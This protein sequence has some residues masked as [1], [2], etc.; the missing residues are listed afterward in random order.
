MSI[1]GG[2]RFSDFGKSVRSG[3]VED[4]G[5]IEAEVAGASRSPS[6]GLNRFRRGGVAPE[7]GPLSR[8][9]ALLSRPIKD[10]SA[11]CVARSAKSQD[12][13]QRMVAPPHN[14]VAVADTRSGRSASGGLPWRS[15]FQRGARG[16]GKPACPLCCASPSSE[17]MDSGHS[18][19]HSSLE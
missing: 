2:R 15:R 10:A 1:L 13:L 18:Q 4:F 11:C 12:G 6:A 7:S 19:V 9:G 14:K 8:G 16:R 3:S 17:N 5:I